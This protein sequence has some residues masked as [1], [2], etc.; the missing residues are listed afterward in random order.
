MKARLVVSSINSGDCARNYVRPVKGAPHAP[1][2]ATNEQKPGGAQEIL[3]T[4]QDNN[5]PKDE[6]DIRI[7]G[8][9]M[10]RQTDND[11]EGMGLVPYFFSYAARLAG[12]AI[13]VWSRVSMLGND[14]QFRAVS[15]SKQILGTRYLFY[16]NVGFDPGFHERRSKRIHSSFRPSVGRA[17]RTAS[18]AGSRMSLAQ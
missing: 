9:D 4:L 10:I 16:R 8:K 15:V 1:V 12:E 11:F 5:E 14:R 17:I 18:N 2:K 13:S 3:E 6:L 7:T